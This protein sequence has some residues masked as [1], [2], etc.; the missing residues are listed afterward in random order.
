MHLFSV[1][2]FSEFPLDRL[3]KRLD[4]R[5]LICPGTNPLDIEFLELRLLVYQSTQNTKPLAS[6]RNRV[7][8]KEGKDH[9]TVD[10][11]LVDFIDGLKQKRMPCTHPYK[12][13]DIPA[14][15]LELVCQGPGLLFG[16]PAE[17]GST[18]DLT[19]VTLRRSSSKC[20][21]RIRDCLSQRRK[22]YVNDFGIR[23]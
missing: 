18:P 16:E 21:D 8:W 12:G 6:C 19:V 1:F 2:E 20:R 17:R 4:V 7:L 15:P 10:V 9:E 23:E 14:T 3:H 5:R 13:F 11:C 22:F